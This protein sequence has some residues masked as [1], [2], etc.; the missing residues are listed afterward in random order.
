ML[1]IPFTELQVATQYCCLGHAS[2]HL[3]HVHLTNQNARLHA[4][5]VCS[6]VRQSHWQDVCPL[7]ML[8]NSPTVCIHA[9]TNF[10]KQQALC[11]SCW[12]SCS[13]VSTFG[14]VQKRPRMPQIALV[15]RGLA[16]NPALVTSASTWETSNSFCMPHLQ[17]YGS[18]LQADR[19]IE[20]L[21]E[22]LVV[23]GIAGPSPA[24]HIADYVGAFAF[25][26]TMLAKAKNARN[27]SLPQIR[28][29]I[30][31][32]ALLPLGSQY[33]WDR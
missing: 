16:G 23:S 3:G 8:Q 21:Y 26:A 30:T 32:F 4:K 18:W 13:S 24:S 1:P 7:V 11:T 31:E 6:N 33:A 27:P 25:L 14:Y 2:D 22:Q 29:A 15:F 10:P 12:I 5:Y 19:S 28:Q 9:A 17:K 20:S